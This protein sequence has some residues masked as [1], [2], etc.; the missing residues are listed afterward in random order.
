MKKKT[1]HL[2]IRIRIDINFKKYLQEHSN[3][4]RDFTFLSCNEMK[5]ERRK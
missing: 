5:N 4:L 1:K 2:K 3:N